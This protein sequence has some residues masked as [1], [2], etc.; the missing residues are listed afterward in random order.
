[1]LALCRAPRALPARSSGSAMLPVVSV[2]SVL[3]SRETPADAPGLVEAS[4][5]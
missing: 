4:A 1:M 2:C 5:L 3:V